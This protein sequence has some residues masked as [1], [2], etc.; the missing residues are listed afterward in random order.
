MDS[1]LCSVLPDCPPSAQEKLTDNTNKVLLINYRDSQLI[2]CG[3]LFQGACTVRSLQNI[4]DEWQQVREPVVANDDK[5]S[6]V[7]FIARGPPNL[8]NTEVQCD[9]LHHFVNNFKQT[10]ETAGY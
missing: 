1:P 9:I 3:S 7:A 5:S 4:S 2:S 8:N 6:T 10:W